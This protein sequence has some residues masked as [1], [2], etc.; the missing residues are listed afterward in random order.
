MF[1]KTKALLLFYL[2]HYLT[3]NNSQPNL[4]LLQEKRQ[5]SIYSSTSVLKGLMIPM[6]RKASPV[7]GRMCPFLL[8]CFTKQESTPLLQ[9]TKLGYI[10]TK[11]Y[12]PMTVF[13]KDLQD[14]LAN[15]LLH[16]NIWTVSFPLWKMS[17]FSHS[18]APENFARIKTRI[19]NT[20]CIWQGIPN[21]GF[22]DHAWRGCRP[23]STWNAA[24][25]DFSLS[26]P[27]SQSTAV[28][29]K[30]H[31]CPQRSEAQTVCSFSS[32]KIIS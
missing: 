12:I 25:N 29:V 14:L 4:P 1:F 5:L 18:V 2:F 23:P 28:A 16:R 22:P 7:L 3:F 9:V 31:Y 8:L 10:K 11:K 19:K 32:H 17:L 30:Q 26:P 13:F 20:I 24:F 27:L 15:S 21:E 6:Q